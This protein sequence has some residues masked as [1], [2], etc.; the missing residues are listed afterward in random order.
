MSADQYE[1]DRPAQIASETRQKY[2]ADPSK[3]PEAR[4][5]EAVQELIDLK[6]EYEDMQCK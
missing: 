3:A 5:E 4:L 1:A 6:V 2:A